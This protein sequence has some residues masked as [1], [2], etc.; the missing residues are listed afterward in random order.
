MVMYPSNHDFEAWAALGNNGWGAQEMGQY[1]RKFQT[2][3]SP[4]ESTARI[5]GTDEYM[6]KSQ[7]GSHGPLPVGFPSVYGPFNQAWDETF[8]ALGWRDN[9]DPITG[10]RLGAFTSPLSVSTKESTRGYAASYYTK[11]VAQRPNFTLWTETQVEKILFA[12]D[13]PDEHLTATGVRVR[14]HNAFLEATSQREVILSAGSLHSPQILELSGIGNSN[15]LQDH[16]IPALINLAGVGENLQDHCTTPISYKVAESDCPSDIM[17]DPP[18]VQSYTRFIKKAEVVQRRL[19]DQHLKLDRGKSLQDCPQVTN[20]EQLSLLRQF[21]LDGQNATAEYILFPLELNTD[22]EDM[23]HVFDKSSDGNYITIVAMLSHP[24]SLGSVHTKSPDIQQKPTFDPNYLS[25][26]LD[27]EIL[28]RHTQFID[29][30]AH[31]E[32]LQKLI[33][34]TRM[35]SRKWLKTVSSPAF[36]P[37]GTCA[38]MPV[39]IGGVVDTNLKVHGTR[40]LRVVDASVFP[41]LPQGNIQT[42]VYAV[43]E[44]AGDLIKQSTDKS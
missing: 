28:A 27:L 40:N 2:Y 37:A 11:E 25:H 4:D 7:Q 13:N 14:S 31:T 42:T 24:F 38:M 8:A 35:R 15:T 33:S 36:H 17:R 39:E 26:P 21:L 3:T 12:S 18:V 43:A 20:K 19:V 29:L 5:L 34:Q 6:K 10:E 16:N 41:L 44:R 32:P 23:A 22:A 30:L 1:L 9:T